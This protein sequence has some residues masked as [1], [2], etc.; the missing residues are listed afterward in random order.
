[1]L[2]RQSFA[3]QVT[4]ALQNSVFFST[5]NRFPGLSGKSLDLTAFQVSGVE[6]ND[7][8]Q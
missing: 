2:P 4:Q 1:M 8:Y 7:L 5:T 6:Y 3:R